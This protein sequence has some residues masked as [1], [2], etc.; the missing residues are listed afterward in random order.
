MADNS[1]Q[2][3]ECLLDTK[4]SY[5]GSE[6]HA[7]RTHLKE[8]QERLEK[9]LAER[10]TLIEEQ[11]T[12]TNGRVT[13]LE[14]WQATEDAKDEVYLSARSWVQPVITGLVTAILVLIVTVVVTGTV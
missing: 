1:E 5:L 7:T 4:L 8:G 12:K 10:L 3:L 9:H 11:V 14:R 6:I 13:A 2:V